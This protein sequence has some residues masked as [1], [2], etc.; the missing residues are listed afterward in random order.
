MH[1]TGQG[2]VIANDGK[3]WTVS[4][5]DME[6]HGSAPFGHLLQARYDE[7]W[8]AHFEIAHP[9]SFAPELRCVAFTLAEIYR[10]PIEHFID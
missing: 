6:R 1:N 7:A 5:A 2:W 10:M 9:S 3:H 4:V 8:N